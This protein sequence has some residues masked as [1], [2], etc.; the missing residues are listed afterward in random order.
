M[1]LK[2]TRRKKGPSVSC[3]NADTCGATSIYGFD[4]VDTKTN[5][6]RIL[7]ADCASEATEGGA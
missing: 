3:D 5:T 7:C 4:V 2:A 1:T 6:R